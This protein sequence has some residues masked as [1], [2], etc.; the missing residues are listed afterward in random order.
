M[1]SLILDHD[2]GWKCVV[3]YVPWVLYIQGKNAYYGQN[4]GPGG[5]RASIKVLDKRQHI[6]KDI[7][8][9]TEGKRRVETQNK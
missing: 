8:P 4:R 9:N 1:A 6:E 7:W 5:P 2:T 3:S